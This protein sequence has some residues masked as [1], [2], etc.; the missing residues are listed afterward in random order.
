MSRRVNVIHQY[1]RHLVQKIWYQ[2]HPLYLLLLPFSGLYR[3]AWWIKKRAYHWQLKKVTDLPIPVIVVGN[4]TVGGTGK[5]PLLIALTHF[6]RDQGYRPGIVSRGYGSQAA[7]FPWQ[8]LANSDP[9]QSGD[10]PLLIAKKTGCPVVIDPNRVRAAQ[11]L[12]AHHDCNIILSDDGL[13]HTALGRQIEIIVMDGERSLEN[14]YLLPAGP[15]R[16]PISRLKTADFVVIKTQHVALDIAQLDLHVKHHLPSTVY[17]LQ[18]MP[19]DPVNLLDPAQSFS[20]VWRDQT[21]HAVAGIGY[22]PHFFNQLRALQFK[23]IEHPFPDHH[24]YQPKDLDFGPDAWVIMTEKDA[25]KCQP[26]SNKGYWYLPVS[27]V[28]GSMPEAL[29][30][31]L[32]SRGL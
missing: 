32:Q 2:K 27:A 15:W 24:D 22:P 17:T 18:L 29:L 9:L 12:L 3:L 19:A 25:V 11:T 8:V 14:Q 7:Q 30:E 21:W 6:L 28:C 1:F 10:E 4:L 13:Q 26:F 16:E 23:I 31:R 20:P 5:T